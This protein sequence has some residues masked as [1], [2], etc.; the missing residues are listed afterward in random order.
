MTAKAIEAGYGVPQAVAA[1]DDGT[2]QRDAQAG[3]G[4]AA[5]STMAPPAWELEELSKCAT[6]FVVPDM[7]FTAKSIEEHFF[8][9]PEN[10][11]IERRVDHGWL[12]PAH[13]RRIMGSTFSGEKGRM[14]QAQHWVHDLS[15]K[16]AKED[17]QLCIVCPAD[18]FRLANERKPKYLEHVNYSKA[19]GYPNQGDYHSY[20][21]GLTGIIRHGLA[22]WQQ[23]GGPPLW[24]DEG[25]W[26]DFDQ[27][28]S[29]GGPGSRGEV[30]SERYFR[31]FGKAAKKAW[32]D[33]NV[34]WTGWCKEVWQWLQY[35]ETAIANV[36]KAKG[37]THWAKVRWEFFAI[38]AQA[39]SSGD[40]MLTIAND[41]DGRPMA[42]IG[43]RSPQSHSHD[44]L[45]P[46]R[47][48][49]KIGPADLE[50]IPNMVHGTQPKYHESILRE[51][52]MSATVA[53]K[54]FRQ[55]KGDR[56]AASLMRRS[57]VHMSPWMPDDS[58]GRSCVKDH[59]QVY[60]VM[61][62]AGVLEA[63]EGELWISRLGTILTT[64]TIPANAI[65]QAWY[66]PDVSKTT[67]DNVRG[68]ED[69]DNLQSQ[70][71]LWVQR[72]EVGPRLRG[73]FF[74][75]A[76]MPDFVR[77]PPPPLHFTE[78]KANK[79]K[80][81]MAFARSGG[82]EWGEFAPGGG[83]ASA[84]SELAMCGTNFMLQDGSYTTTAAQ[85]SCQGC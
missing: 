19:W 82:N 55:S 11:P 42:V 22:G 12:K 37:E 28:A 35:C 43:I 5:L 34:S 30:T 51:G 62:K 46:E 68:P 56:M 27:V 8:G 36:A 41:A 65:M 40:R 48:L 26:C 70:W 31:G 16:L 17:K 72:P 18:V 59:C 78:Y 74:R 83:F 15:K 47:F 44:W 33:P 66:H 10:L 80:G 60:Y 45:N 58:R 69:W 24:M 13:D 76:T 38:A 14:V 6:P 84:K 9:D 25:G 32:E 20:Q 75:E 29:A 85:D 49:A 79:D 73:P 2:G 57:Q 63:V 4:V 3:D 64:K 52:L 77:L 61:D 71:Q 53:K 1:L 23:R 54:N 39:L 21:T 67:V 7:K 81:P 50:F